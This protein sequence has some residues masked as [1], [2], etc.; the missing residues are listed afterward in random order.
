MGIRPRKSTR[1]RGK[2]PKSPSKVLR[3]ISKTSLEREKRDQSTT[4]WHLYTVGRKGTSTQRYLTFPVDIS[5]GCEN[6]ERSFRYEIDPKENWRCGLIFDATLAQ[7]P[8][9]FFCP[10]QFNVLFLFISIPRLYYE[11]AL[12]MFQR[13]EEI[14][15]FI[16]HLRK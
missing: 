16:N 3:T 15:F 10:S 6:L 9:G 13:R 7:G 14:E 12:S 11:G 4:R 2:T 8:R 5:L 1:R